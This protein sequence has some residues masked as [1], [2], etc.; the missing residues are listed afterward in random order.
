MGADNVDDDVDGND[1]VDD[2]D[3]DRDGN[4]GADNIAVA[5]FCPHQELLTS[6]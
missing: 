5:V 4:D 2:D 1:G 6:S 3:D